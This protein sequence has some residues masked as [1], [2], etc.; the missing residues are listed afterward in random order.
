M[1]HFIDIK[2]ISSIDLRKIIDRAK[3]RKLNRSKLG[4]SAADP[5]ALLDQKV[6]AMFFEQPSLRTRVSFD[7]AAKQLGGQTLILNKDDIHYGK[8]EESIHD[9]A[10]LISEY[11]D[12]L[13]LRTI[14]HQNVYVNNCL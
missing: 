13:M 4:K 2:D 7:I 6:L 9:T 12:V 1:K 14:S 5:N 10:K 11:A 8:G 3:K